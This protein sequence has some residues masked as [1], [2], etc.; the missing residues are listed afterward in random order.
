[1]NDSTGHEFGL[2]AEPQEHALVVTVMGR[3]DGINAEDFGRDLGRQLAGFDERAVI[4]DCRKTT[5]VSSAGL[6]EILRAAKQ[7]KNARARLMMCG[8][9]DAVLK[10]IK[11]AG[12]DM[13]IDIHPDVAA[14]VAAAAG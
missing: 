4:L 1:M 9:P 10:V 12:F 6:R 7:R 8:I 5:Y 11:I 13:V 3:I 14:A 2:H